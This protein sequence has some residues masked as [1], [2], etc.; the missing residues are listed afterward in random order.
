MPGIARCPYCA[1]NIIGIPEYR[2]NSR[3]LC[4]WLIQEGAARF[5][6]V[7]TQRLPEWQIHPQH[8]QHACRATERFLTCAVDFTRRGFGARYTF[9]L[10]L[11][12]G[13]FAD[14]FRDFYFHFSFRQSCSYFGGLRL[15]VF[16]ARP[17]NFYYDVYKYVCQDLQKC[18]I[19]TY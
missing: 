14:N 12:G 8:N 13:T 7:F 10:S 6:Q 4:L 18:Y 17:G 2:Q 9:S 19:A 11:K 3:F 15:S 16:N 1:P 5:M